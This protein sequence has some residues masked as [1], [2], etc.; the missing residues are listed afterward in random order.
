MVVKGGSGDEGFLLTLK[1]RCAL[2]KFVPQLSAVLYK[3]GT[4]ST[5]CNVCTRF[6]VK[7]RSIENKKLVN[8]TPKEDRALASRPGAPVFLGKLAPRLL[9]FGLSRNLSPTHLL[10]QDRK[11]QRR[12]Q[13]C[14]HSLQ[15][16]EETQD[17]ID[18]HLRWDTS[19]VLEIFGPQPHQSR[20]FEIAPRRSRYTCLPSLDEPIFE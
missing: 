19:V 9:Q 1:Y 14:S 13:K 12:F 7:L 16:K 6:F 5:I 4:S 20:H 2:S 3:L 11:A 10:R 8:P 17:L 18:Q 15:C